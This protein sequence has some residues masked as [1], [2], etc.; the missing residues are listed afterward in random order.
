MTFRPAHVRHVP[1]LLG[2]GVALAAF[3]VTPLWTSST[4]LA[5]AQAPDVLADY[6]R[7][8]SLRQ[9]VTGMAVDVIADNAWIDGTTKFWY[10]KSV[11]GG[12]TF[13]LVD[14]TAGTKTPAFDHARLA[15]A[16]SAASGDRYT[17]VTL[18]FTTLQFVD[19]QQTIEFGIGAG[20]AATRWR[21]TLSAYDCTRVTGAAGAGGGRAGGQGRGG[22][23]A[24][25]AGAAADSLVR[26]A[27]NGSAEAVIRNFNV[28]VRS[29]PDGTFEPLSTD[30]SEGNGY[31]LNSLR[32]SP[33]STKIAVFKRRPGYNR[34]V[35]YI[36]TSP[37]DQVQPKHS[38]IF[39]RKP[40]DEV[41]FDLPVIFNLAT[42]TTHVG[43]QTLFPNPY[44]NSRL[45]WRE[46]SRAI[47]FEYNQ[48]GHQVYRVLELDATSGRT[49]TVI[50]EASR[51]F[52]EYSGKRIREDVADGRQIIWGSERDG[53]NHLYMYDGATG[54]MTQQIT[55]GQ[56]VVRGVDRVDADT[57]QI[58]FRASGMHPGQDPYFIHAYR[59]SFDGTGLTALTE[60]D[61]THTVTWSPDRQFYVDTWSRVDLAPVAQMRRASD[62]SVVMDLERGDIAPLLTTGW[63]APEVFVSKARDGQT[64]IW[65]IIIRPTNF[66]PAKTYPVIENIYAGPQGSFVP[67][68]FSTQLGMQAQAELG[69]IVVQI[70]GMGTSNRSK[71]F[72]DVAWKNLGDAGFPDRI[73]WHKAVAAKYPW[74]DA[75][76]VGVYGTSAGGQN[77]TGALL[78]HPGFYDV[79]VSAVGCHDNRMDKIWWNEQWMGWPI[80]PEYAASSNVDHAKNLQGRMLLIVGELDTNVDP[81]STMQVVNA[82]IRANKDFDLLVIPGAGHGAGGAYGERRRF[83]FFVKHLRGVEPPN[84]NLPAANASGE[85]FDQL[86]PM[87]V[88]SEDW[89]VH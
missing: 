43:D 44:A 21:C 25:Q 80:G 72:H 4:S 12:S 47:T 64:D 67:K 24:G 39:Y 19:A 68:T 57:R 8:S 89:H 42:R 30:G 17:A 49:R 16:L 73:I 81:A 22:G 13:T 27:P 63:R 85:A 11:S 55:R 33:D 52:V 29:L 36:E 84:W 71:A 58:W 20:P 74:Y 53:W 79:A 83:D 48:R 62:Q 3:V 51:T 45:A 69:F 60:A 10:R 54:R 66:D 76:R 14:A 40:G 41:D 65:G 46:D 5:G 82:L 77:A 56:W 86:T 26:R 1:R 38:S 35:H 2:A 37:T 50:E 18:P 88:A 70:D 61:G 6:E 9:R 87:W 28:W 59:I 31:T 23:Q 34:Q 78:F 15:A 7:A 32:W 75:T